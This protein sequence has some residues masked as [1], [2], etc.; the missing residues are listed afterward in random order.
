MQTDVFIYAASDHVR[1]CKMHALG[2]NIMLSSFLFNHIRLGQPKR[3][4]FNFRF[5]TKISIFSAIEVNL[6]Y[7][8]VYYFSTTT[9]II[10]IFVLYLF[11]NFFT[12]L[13][14]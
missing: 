14:Y 6:Q 11:T 5:Q 13:L 8:Q 3:G 2:D 4:L 1:R 12:C 10:L 7:I 9:I